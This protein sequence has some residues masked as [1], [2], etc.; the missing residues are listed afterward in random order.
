MRQFFGTRLT[1]MSF[2]EWL[3]G[4][5]LKLAS[6]RRG[7]LSAHHN[8][9]SLYMLHADSGLRAFYERS[10]ECYIDGMAIRA[11]L[12]GAGITS[13]G[14]HRFSLMDTFEQLLAHA[15]QRDWTIYY[16]GSQESVVEQA[17]DKVSRL[18][19]NLG[20]TLHH[21]YFEN[22]ALI[23]SRINA[24]R[25]D[26]LLV[27]MGMPAQESWLLEQLDRLDVAF[28][29]EVGAT[30]DYFTDAQSKPPLWLSRIGMAWF[31]RLLHD[32]ARLWRRY[33]LEPWA[34]FFPTIKLWLRR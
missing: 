19:P 1:P 26:L 13:R 21:G 27:G 12:A 18:Y 33:L 7:Y 32:P 11:L 30:L 17:R 16:L 23:V 3:E 4:I 31:Y 14:E 8:L 22:D 9:H 28:A 34:L 2:H 24:V 25:P 29:T 5:S 6:G 10:D 20:I 15:E